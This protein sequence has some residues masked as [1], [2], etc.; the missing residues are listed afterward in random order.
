VHEILQVD[1]KDRHSVL[2]R[3]QL[4]NNLLKAG[5]IGYAEKDLDALIENVSFEG[6]MTALARYKG[7][8]VFHLERDMTALEKQIALKLGDLS[9]EDFQKFERF[10][11]RTNA[12][13]QHAE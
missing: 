13:T 5:I 12:F 4:I 9:S 8:H 3:E 2:T 10:R 1:Y 11:E 6:K 7:G